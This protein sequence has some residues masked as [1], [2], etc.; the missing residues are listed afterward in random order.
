MSEHVTANLTAQ[1]PQAS[2]ALLIVHLEQDGS[3]STHSVP[4]S[5]SAS[6]TVAA[7]QKTRRTLTP[8]RNRVG[9][10]FLLRHVV[11][12]VVDIVQVLTWPTSSSSPLGQ[13]NNNALSVSLTAAGPVVL[14]GPFCIQVGA[15]SSHEL[16]TV[17][18]ASAPTKDQGLT[19][20]LAHPHRL[21]PA[22]D[23]GFLHNYQSLLFS[24]G[25]GTFPAKAL[26]FRWEADEKAMVG[27]RIALMAANFAVSLAVK[28]AH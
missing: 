27:V 4:V 3:Y 22:N 14:I 10:R 11:V 25:S 2:R 15:D 18:L 19:A 7:V 1:T 26:M 9:N 21:T 12:D 28:L 23:D 20:A 17:K 13:S 6:A 16:P 5:P 8:M 24:A